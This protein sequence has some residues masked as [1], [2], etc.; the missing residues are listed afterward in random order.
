[1]A[2]PKMIKPEEKPPLIHSKINKTPVNTES[3]EAMTRDTD[4]TV[5]GTFVNIEC[6]GQPGTVCGLYYKGMQ[7]FKKVFEDG[8]NCKIPLSVAR[9]INEKSAYEQHSYLQD[10]KGNPL[11]TGKKQP[12]YK[13]MIEHMA[14]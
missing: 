1:M 3:I 8:E 5:S 11:K 4:K 10:E 13:F 7:Y 9:W 12:R 2:A 14:A 6:P